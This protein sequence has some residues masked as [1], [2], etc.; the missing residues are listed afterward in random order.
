MARALQIGGEDIPAPDVVAATFRQMRESIVRS[1]SDDV[2]V[3]LSD[4]VWLRPGFDVRSDFLS[5]CRNAFDAEVGTTEMGE[6][7][8][9]AINGFVAE[10]THGRIAGLLS[11]PALDDPD[12]ALVAIG[13]VYL[14]AKWQVPFMRSAT[15]GQVFHAPIGDVETQ[16]VHDTREAEILETPECSALRFRRHASRS[17]RMERPPPPRPQSWCNAP[18]WQKTL[19]R[20]SLSQTVRSFSSSGIA[21]AALSFSSVTCNAP[22]RRTSSGRRQTEIVT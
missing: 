20:V 19:R 4:S 2:E 18:P 10:R 21:A 9:R 6:A 5:I 12:T 15:Y 17:T 1:A 14:K 22:D 13:T 16:F 8:R 3:E 7:G 11:P